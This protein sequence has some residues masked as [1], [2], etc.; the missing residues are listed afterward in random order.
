MVD[1][2]VTAAL[3]EMSVSEM[4]SKLPN[5]PLPR[6]LRDKIYGYLLDGDYTRLERPVNVSENE[7][8]ADLYSQ[9]KKDNAYHFHTNVMALNHAIHDEA[10]ELL[11]KRNVFVVVS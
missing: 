8:T 4:S 5:F 2:Q 3:S 6:E 10:E 11:Y 7:T 9:V 1:E